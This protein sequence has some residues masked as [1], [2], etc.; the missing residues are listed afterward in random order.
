ML[1]LKEIYLL[2]H[3]SLVR[4]GDSTPTIF[5][6]SF[7]SNFCLLILCVSSFPIK[8]AVCCVASSY[9]HPSDPFQLGI[10]PT[11]FIPDD[12]L[13]RSLNFIYLFVQGFCTS[14]FPSRLRTAHNKHCNNATIRIKRINKNNQYIQK[15]NILGN[16]MHSWSGINIKENTKPSHGSGGGWTVRGW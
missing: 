3:R 2:P 5:F 6:T 12:H 1:S 10:K 13:V 16:K 15:E 4:E 14:S 7:L 8:Q 11:T 9:R